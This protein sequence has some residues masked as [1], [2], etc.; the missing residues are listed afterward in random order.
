MFFGWGDDIS[1]FPPPLY[2]TLNSIRLQHAIVFHLQV[3]ATGVI[4]VRMSTTQTESLSAKSNQTFLSIISPWCILCNVWHDVQVSG[5][6]VWKNWWH[7]STLSQDNQRE[8]EVRCELCEEFM[9]GYV[10]VIFFFL[11]ACVFFLLAWC[12]RQGELPLSPCQCG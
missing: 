10:P 2:E 5:W 3:N 7:V 9:Y 8:G 1:G 12:L 4:S 11:D 6:F